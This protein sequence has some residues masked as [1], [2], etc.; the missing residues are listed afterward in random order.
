MQIN[1]SVQKKMKKKNTTI[2][3]SGKYENKLKYIFP[4][5]AWEQE[6][7]IILISLQEIHRR[8]LSEVFVFDNNFL[9][10]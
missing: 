5:T 3:I 9:K 4:R 6:K 1:D 2:K 10:T 8:K 7:V